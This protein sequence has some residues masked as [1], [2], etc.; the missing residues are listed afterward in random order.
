M[1]EE[2][3]G[4]MRS[5][6]EKNIGAQLR[7]LEKLVSIDSGSGN[8]KGVNAVSEVI[9]QELL[10]LGFSVRLFSYENA[11]NCL[12]ADFANDH[13]KILLLGHMDTV[14]PDGEA[15]NRPF[16]IK[17]DRAYG[18]GV[19]DMKGGVSQMIFA[20]KALK[21]H[22]VSLDR[23]Q[24][25]LGGDEEVGHPNS[26]VVKIME[27]L[28][29]TTDFV[30]CFESVRIDG[31]LVTGRKGVVEL[32]LDVYGKS[33][34][35]GNDYQS[36]ANAILELSHKIISLQA[37]NAPD[38]SLT[39]N[40]GNITGGGAINIVPDY[41]QASFDIRIQN[42][43]K[44]IAFEKSLKK[45]CANRNVSGTSCEYTLRLEYPPMIQNDAITLMIDLVNHVCTDNGHPPVETCAVGGGADSSYFAM[46][47]VPV[48]CAFG[49]RGEKNHTSEE[50][51][52]ID[53]LKE[54]TLLLAECIEYIQNHQNY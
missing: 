46:Y 41:A 51:I 49:P 10:D 50:Y 34:H 52:I 15:A 28:S 24:V 27:K 25:L 29:K 43:E 35:A 26:D 8:I 17:G 33:A 6:I 12:V 2:G 5:I 20:L 30:F 45:L 39:V 40:A 38:F 11:G 22:G 18:P 13:S 48:V 53:G 32:T 23:V 16:T 54:R 21:E 31:K 44:Y 3:R 9:K 19:L 14:F 47:G 37:L 4:I 1:I 42:Y 36:G 7:L